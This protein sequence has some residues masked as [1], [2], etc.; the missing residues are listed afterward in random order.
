VF[1][2]VRLLDSEKPRWIKVDEKNTSLPRIRI[3]FNLPEINVKYI[4]EMKGDSKYPFVHS[5][6]IPPIKF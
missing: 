1:I 3:S 6:S 4:I 2:F 5:V